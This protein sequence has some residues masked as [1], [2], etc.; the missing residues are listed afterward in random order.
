MLYVFVAE[1]NGDLAGYTKLTR[2]EMLT[3]LYNTLKLLGRVPGRTSDKTPA[4]FS[5][6]EDVA[7]W[8]REPCFTLLNEALSAA[9]TV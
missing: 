6:E 3:F 4:S 8:A 2:H 7:S 1:Y 9:A 5:D